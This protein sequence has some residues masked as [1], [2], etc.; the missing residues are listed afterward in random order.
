VSFLGFQN[1]TVP[2]PWRWLKWYFRK[3]HLS[4]KISN[5]LP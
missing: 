2:E 5:S 1:R 4:M 3:H